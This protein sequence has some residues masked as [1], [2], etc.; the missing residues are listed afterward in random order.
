MWS[1]FSVRL[2]IVLPTTTT[3]CFTATWTPSDASL[4][5]AAE[6][7]L[8]RLVCSGA[9]VCGSVLSSGQQWPHR[10]HCAAPC[11]VSTAPAQEPPPDV[12]QGGPGGPA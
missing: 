10:V 11:A 2:G 9:T 5:P 4:G 12:T 6:Q 1:G 3:V 7:V 8:S